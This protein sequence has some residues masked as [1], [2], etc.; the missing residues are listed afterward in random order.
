M[1]SAIPMPGAAP[2]ARTPAPGP[3]RTAPAARRP[4]RA[5]A[6]AAGAALL[7]AALLGGCAS[8]ETT[9]PRDA[10]EQAADRPPSAGKGGSGDAAGLPPG[11]VDCR[12][13]KC[14]AL[15][16]DAGP[17]ED[18]PR[19]L[20]V[21]KREHVH[22]T[23][24]LLG[25]NHVMKHPGTVRRIAAEG[26]ELGNHTWSHRILTGIGEA[27]V[28]EELARTQDAVERIT[29]RR[30]AVMRPPQ[31]RTD[32]K[33]ARVSRE[34]GLAQVLWSVSAK[35]YATDDPAVIEKRVLDQ[36]GRDG[37]VLLHDIYPGTVP[38]VPGILAGL[39]QRG[40]TVVTFSQ[41]LA[42]AVPEPGRVYKP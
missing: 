14:I 33:V 20:D 10:R 22:A 28:R 9:A 2:V 37:V 12:K 42:P 17:G 1:P 35:D 24:F 25:A 21:L 23:F 41:L 18:T 11:A 19:L 27:Q 39:K 3:S 5:R 8:Y 6:L 4:G 40:Y 13:A 34:L 31:G 7:A 16:F 26:H 32:G 36:A 15:T 29:G 38:A 30:P